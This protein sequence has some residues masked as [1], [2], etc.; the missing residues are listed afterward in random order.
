[1]GFR[2]YVS[3]TEFFPHA[4]TRLV[5]RNRG[6]DVLNVS[7]IPS[8]VLSGGD[9]VRV[10]YAPTGSAAGG[11]TVFVG[12]VEQITAS[13]LPGTDS[14]V[15]AVV[16][17]PW[18]KLERLVYQQQWMDYSARSAV[19][20][21]NLVL[22]QDL[23]G[24][25]IGFKTQLNDIF[26][27]AKA[28]VGCTATAISGGQELP[29]DEV[30]D[31]SCAQAINR[32]LRWF[33]KKIVRFDYSSGTPNIELADPEAASWIDSIDKTSVVRTLSGHPISGV[34][35]ETVTTGEDDGTPYRKIGRQIYPASADPTGVD[36]LHASIQLAGA[37]ASTTREFLRVHCDDEI[38]PSSSG[39]WKKY[40]PRLAKARVQDI[41][42]KQWSTRENPEDYPNKS[43]ASVEELIKF[44]L[45]ARVETFT[46]QIDLKENDDGDREEGLVL[47][48]K[49][50]TT[51][52][53]DDKTYV[54][55]VGATSTTGETI[56]ANLA[57]AIY[58]DRA[59]ALLELNCQVRLGSAIPKVGETYEGLVLQSA[60]IDPLELTANCFFGQSEHLSPEDMASVLSGFR[61]RIRSTS[62][63]ERSEGK[64]GR[65]EEP[66][67]V[68][69]PTETT[70]FA[71]GAKARATVKSATG[72]GKILLDPS[73]LAPGKTVDVH[74]LTVGKS[75]LKIL[76]EED[77]EIPDGGGGSGFKGTIRVA[78]GE[79]RCNADSGYYIQSEYITCNVENGLVK[80]VV[81]DANGQPKKEWTTG[82]ATTPLSGT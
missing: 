70:E 68:I 19:W 63:W 22:N 31:L 40:H 38:D 54:R 53:E 79:Q 64:R 30:R 13:A 29:F 42:V 23:N 6:V 82:L 49:F 43:D 8:G 39:W 65:D 75:S 32:V 78:T 74:T 71:P 80:S 26:N 5:F 59:G 56:P 60:E 21:S 44:G 73:K 11:Q 46:A 37:S 48:M 50:V 15:D 16:S 52:A 20:S 25:S 61:N 69:G 24:H 34:C 10:T 72:G 28:R 17:S 41:T 58:E 35:L 66:P 81:L 2:F 76:A 4:G 77:I 14:S 62:C 47:Q 45:K 7:S 9:T 33:P 3:D 27:F 51:N 12:T 1:M 36:V 18:A 55:T 67:K 57:R